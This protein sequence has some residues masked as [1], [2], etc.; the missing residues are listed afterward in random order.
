MVAWGLIALAPALP[1]TTIIVDF[2]PHASARE[3]GYNEANVTWGDADEADDRV[4][5]EAFAACELQHYL[6]K[7]TGAPEDFG[8]VNAG[9]PVSD[10]V[11]LRVGRAAG[12]AAEELQALGPEGYVIRSARRDGRRV[13]L[14]AGGGRVGTLYGVYDFLHRL[15]VRWYAPGEVNEEAPSKTLDDLPD[16]DIRETP[17]F[18]TRGFHAWEDRGDEEFL[19]WMARNRLNYWCVQQSDK[20]LL[21]KLGIMLLGGGHVL[22]D[23]YLGPRL[24]YP[25]NH[26]R[27]TGDDG[28]PDDPYAIS[29]EYKGDTN[30]DGKLTSFEAHP[31]WY[32][33]RAGKRSDRISGGGGDNFC[34]SNEDAVTEWMKNAIDD[35]AEGRYK[36]AG[37][38]NAWTLDGGKWCECENCK[39]LGTRTDRNILLV[40]RYAQEIKKAQ[41]AGRINRPVRLLFL[42]YADVLEPPTKPLPEGFD[43]DTCIATYFP[44]VRCYVHNFDDSKCDAN[45]R[46][47]KHLHGWAAGGRQRKSRSGDR[48][49]KAAEVAAGSRSYEAAEVAAGS[50]SHEAGD[51][52]HHYQGQICIGE[53]YNVSGYKCLPICFMRTMANDIPYYYSLGARHFH[54]MHC[55]TQDWG[56]KALTNWQMARQ[57]WDQDADCE[58]L[59]EDYFAGRYGSASAQMR[60]FYEALEKT[61]CNI[62]QLKYGLARRL[63]RGS[64][65]LFPNAHLRYEKS[66]SE[67]SMGPSLVE[68][69]EH[70]AR[71]R[72]IIN[73]VMKM[74]LPQRIAHRVA[75]DERLF[76]YGGRTVEFYDVLCRTYFAIRE[77][78]R[79]EA[80]QTFREAQELAGLLK[81]D[82]TSTKF[83]SSHASAPNALSASYAS[84]ALGKLAM[85]L[86]PPAPEEVRLFAPPGPLVMLGKEF[87][88]GGSMKYGFGF[89]A[90]PG[91]IRVSESGNFLYG[92]GTHPYDQIIGWFR[93]AKVPDQPL[94]LTLVGVIT[95]VHSKDSIEGQVSVNGALVFKGNMPFEGRKLTP[96]EIEAPAHILKQ[97][98]NTLEIRNTEPNGVVGNRPWFGIDRIELRDTPVTDSPHTLFLGGRF[99][100]MAFEELEPT[101]IS[102]AW[103]YIVGCGGK[104]EA[105]REGRVRD[106]T[107]S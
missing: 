37:I 73:G 62:S 43:Y 64:E 100:K 68:I 102:A 50:R 77:G 3:A 90:Y 67:E 33:L 57:L 6:R 20:P 11:V 12:L 42:A 38:M 80:R 9:A 53:Y 51:S 35:L 96:V 92:R 13:I 69:L 83:S 104:I 91:R 26:P 4:C 10:D 28:K 59:W 71:C 98:V 25:Y 81:A 18:F 65:N 2:G 63:E 29:P 75:E 70:A 58:Q 86:G 19:L 105:K 30:K 101:T 79:D 21:H 36:D 76:T 39:A 44:I 106:V 46:Y 23:Y 17:G 94:Y 40:H 60:E 52:K 61:L 56:N 55:T 49:H 8:I 88:G 66:D 107:A 103:R 82:T 48:S 84:G 89:H 5:T 85:L 1:A 74:D 16:M 27:F 99:E 32:G 15:G 87:L 93:L 41:A 24:A 7:I 54:Y 95:P 97:G 78:K 72:G 45:A 14:V 22:T 31:E 34:T 47:N